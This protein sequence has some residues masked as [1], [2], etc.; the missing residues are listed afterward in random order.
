M[1]MRVIGLVF[2]LL[3][4]S[5]LFSAQSCADPFGGIVN[6]VKKELDIVAVCHDF[7]K[8]IDGD[9]RG[10][11]QELF[12]VKD[13]SIHQIIRIVEEALFSYK[14]ECNLSCDDKSFKEKFFRISYRANPDILQDILVIMSTPDPSRTSLSS[15]T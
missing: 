4:G 6:Q 8:Y 3:Q 10:N 2:V 15:L 5:A 7:A 13:L 9:F 14:K 1:N 12:S 11:N